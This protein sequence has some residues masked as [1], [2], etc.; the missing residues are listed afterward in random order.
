MTKDRDE[1]GTTMAQG[2]RAAEQAVVDQMTA[3]AGAWWLPVVAERDRQLATSRAEAAKA[4]QGAY[5]EAEL[6][7][8]KA[9]WAAEDEAWA[10]NRAELRRRRAECETYV[11]AANRRLGSATPQ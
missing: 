8:I 6:A 4:E 10:R 3:E 7:A 5:S 11:A 9:R 1:A 2:L